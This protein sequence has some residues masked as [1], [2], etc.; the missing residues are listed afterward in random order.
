MARLAALVPR[1]R[2]NLVRYHGVLAPAHP[3]CRQVT[4]T[5]RETGPP[6]AGKG[7]AGSLRVIADVTDPDVIDQILE[8]VFREGLPRAPPVRSTVA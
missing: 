1:P 2:A 6:R 4:G 5:E 8:H 3:W 7:H